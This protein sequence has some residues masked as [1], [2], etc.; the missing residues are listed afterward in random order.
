MKRGIIFITCLFIAGCLSDDA[1]RTAPVPQQVLTKLEERIASLPPGITEEDALKY[2]GFEG[3]K[4]YITNGMGGGSASAYHL[5]YFLR[6]SGVLSIVTD[7]TT[8]KGI[9]FKNRITGKKTQSRQLQPT[10]LPTVQ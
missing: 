4:K 10:T 2:I 6:N 8:L 9:I 5:D 7:G 3:I 1:K